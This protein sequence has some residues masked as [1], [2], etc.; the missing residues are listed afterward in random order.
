MSKKKTTQQIVIPSVSWTL[1]SDLVENFAFWDG[2]FSSEECDA[3]VEAGLKRNLNVATVSN[4]GIVNEDIRKSN[5]V[6]LHPGEIEW[7]Y[8]R[9]TDIVNELNAKFFGFD[10][11]GFGEGL[12]FTE[13]KA[14]SGKYDFHVDRMYSGALRKLSL[15]VQLTDPNKYK[16]GDLELSFGDP[17][18][19]MERTKGRLVA[20]PSFVMHRVKPV[21][22]GTRHSLVAWVNGPQFK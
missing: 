14:P 3:I 10:L 13:Y 21:T 19:K 11:W 15:V 12:Q 5:V 16:G 1:K 20:F 7:A 9:L 6:S 4:E 17:A 8:R 22:K 2:A 18:I